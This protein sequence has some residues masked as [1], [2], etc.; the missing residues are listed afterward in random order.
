M[1]LLKHY[2]PRDD[3]PC[4]QPLHSTMSLLKHKAIFHK[5]VK[6]VSLHSTMSLLKRRGIQYLKVRHPIFTFHYVSIK[7]EEIANILNYEIILYIPLC[8][9]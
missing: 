9:Y 3:E 6:I 1:S 7:T 8:L 4:F 5:D 2:H